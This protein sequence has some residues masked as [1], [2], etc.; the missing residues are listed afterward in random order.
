V[1]GWSQPKQGATCTR[2]SWRWIAQPLLAPAGEDLREAAGTPSGGPQGRSATL[3]GT[4]PAADTDTG[5]I[6][7]RV[8]GS[9]EPDAGGGSRVQNGPD[10]HGR[11]HVDAAVRRWDGAAGQARHCRGRTSS[12]RR[13]VGG[14][15]RSAP[16]A[17]AGGG[18]G[19]A[20]RTR[21]PVGGQAVAAR[22]MA[23]IAV[24][25]MS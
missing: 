23:V 16:C 25:S 2:A 20:R 7:V 6:P 14:R 15:A 3:P 12:S 5:S 1:S 21:L 4:E 18:S 24:A 11:L 9:G 8:K 13:P 10:P 22:C 19:R 17:T